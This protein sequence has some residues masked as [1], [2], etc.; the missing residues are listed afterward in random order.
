MASDKAPFKITIKPRSPAHAKLIMRDCAY[1]AD[2]N[3]QVL[4]PLLLYPIFL[5]RWN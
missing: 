2:P 1:A 5:V 3:V 4:Q